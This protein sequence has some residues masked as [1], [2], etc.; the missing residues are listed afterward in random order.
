MRKNSKSCFFQIEQKHAQRKNGLIVVSSTAAD[1]GRERNENEKDEKTCIAIEIDSKQMQHAVHVFFL[2]F[3]CPATD[4][5][6][7][8]D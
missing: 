4:V 1:G 2:S 6:V 7:F 5:R 8:P 3:F